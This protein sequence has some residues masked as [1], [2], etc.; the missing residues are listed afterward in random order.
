MTLAD[1]GVGR[2]LLYSSWPS[3]FFTPS[4][5]HV[6]QA[7]G[8]T[9]SAVASVVDLAAASDITSSALAYFLMADIFIILCIGI[10]LILPKLEY[11]R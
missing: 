2:G 5:C 8:G 7:M 1:R 11:S 3:L 9:V 6:G 4:L 10:Y